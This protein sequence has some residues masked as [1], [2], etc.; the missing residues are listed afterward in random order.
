MKAPC[1]VGWE[2]ASQL[3]GR[4]VSLLA[5]SPSSARRLPAGLVWTNAG[6]D[7]GLGYLWSAHNGLSAHFKATLA[8]S[9]KNFPQIGLSDKT[10][11]VDRHRGVAHGT[12]GWE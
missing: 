5:A 1:P 8:T 9:D 2:H 10:G 7:K 4:G 6:R 11:N 12:C 3:K